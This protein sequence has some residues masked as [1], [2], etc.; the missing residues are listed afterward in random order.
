MVEHSTDNRVVAG[1]SPVPPT[2]YIMKSKI[3]ELINK[4][5]TKTK[6]KKRICGKRVETQPRKTSYFLKNR[7]R[8]C[9]CGTCKPCK[10]ILSMTY[11]RARECGRPL[12]DISDRN[13]YTEIITERKEIELFQH[14]T[15]ELSGALKFA[16]Y[17]NKENRDLDF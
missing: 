4:A 13:F 9:G 3:L 11:L 17:K 15:L 7:K 2:I 5:K 10:T 16:K 6:N 14:F 12:C 1:S 8:K